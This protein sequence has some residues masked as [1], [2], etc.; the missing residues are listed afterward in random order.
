MILEWI[1]FGIALLV[2]MGIAIIGTCLI[3]WPIGTASGFGLPI[4]KD[5]GFRWWL[6]IKGVRDLTAGLIL[7]CALVWGGPTTLAVVLLVQ[8]LI[9]LGD[10]TTILVARGPVRTALGVHGLT[11]VLMLLAALMFWAAWSPGLTHGL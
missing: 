11:A 3:A 10:M 7:L 8:S 2:G 4:P 9:P 1:A 6:R 5:P